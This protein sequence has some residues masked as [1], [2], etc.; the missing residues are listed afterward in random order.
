MTS[1][2]NPLSGPRPFSPRDIRALTV[3]VAGPVF[4]PGDNGYTEE[5]T[6]FNRA[7][8]HRPAVIVGAADAADVMSAVSF[9]G[10][11]GRP[12][13]VLSTGHG[14]SG[15]VPEDAVLITTRRMTGLSIDAGERTVRVE[16]GVNWRQVV[17]E[18]A[19]HGLA[20]L[21]GSAADV[22]VVGYTLGGGLSVT[23]GRAFGWAADHVQ[24]IDVVTADGEL[25]HASRDSEDDLFWALRGGKSNFGVVTA[26]EFSLF[27]VTQLYAGAL[28]FSGDDAREVLHAYE[29]F[30]TTAPEEVTSSVALLRLPDLPTLPDFMRGRLTVAVRFSWLGSEA[31][32]EGLIAPLRA[33]AP[34]LLDSVELRPYT[35]FDAISADPP[36]GIGAVEHFA[37]LDEVSPDTIDALLDVAGPEAD[38]RVNVVDLRQLGG[39]LS[40]YSGAPNVVGTRDAAFAVFA[41]VF[42]PPGEDRE[43]YRTVGDEV[44]ERLEP[45]LTV[46]KHTNFLGA[47]DAT[48]ERVR[49]AFDAPT[50]ERLQE[51]KAARDPANMFRLNH[52]IP[53]ASAGAGS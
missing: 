12:V 43:E 17:E 34:V 38:S 28:Y 52:N 6:G 46:R 30:T 49:L 20:P 4:L 35:E 19:G 42:V 22:G 23:M 21:V 24:W 48:T 11:Y 40:R 41:F 39:A 2:S 36:E 31:D 27:P 50:Y 29:R 9:A 8:T 26:M 53:P 16:A 1:A 15:D 51:I 10:R 5:A 14:P 45:W 18:A 13:A 33:A 47:N 25:R 37:V 44:M 7:V 3:D 32:G